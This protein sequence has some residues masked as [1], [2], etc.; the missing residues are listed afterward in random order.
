[1]RVRLDLESTLDA[2]SGLSS[3]AH[4]AGC[5][6]SH[7]SQTTAGP[8]VYAFASR[9]G[10]DPSGGAKTN[11]DRLIVK[12]ALGGVTKRA[13]F[14]VLDGH[15]PD[16]NAAAKYVKQ[17]LPKALLSELEF[18]THIGKALSRAFLSVNQDLSISSVDAYVSGAAGAVAMLQGSE[19]TVAHVGDCQVVVG[20]DMTAEERSGGLDLEV[21]AESL[22]PPHRP[23]AESEARRITDA[24][25][26]IFEWGV[27]RVWLADV[28]MPGIAITRSFGDVVAENVGVHAQP[29]ILKLTLT[30]KHKYIVMASDGVWAAM[31]PQEVMNIVHD[32][33]SLGAREAADAVLTQAQTHWQSNEDATDDMSIIVLLL[34]YGTDQG[35][36][37]V[38]GGA[39]GNAGAAFEPAAAAFEFA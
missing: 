34:Y 39:G 26:R 22:T 19:L 13:L 16:G 23:D 14:G 30:P 3:H 32:A 8:V 12:D 4:P 38:P 1:M 35:F 5:P 37:A 11:Q 29:D 25:G 36:A 33:R 10:T 31:P 21:F 15:G 9:G 2:A 17:A 7:L 24:G 27:P 6:H 28:D 20:R 18:E